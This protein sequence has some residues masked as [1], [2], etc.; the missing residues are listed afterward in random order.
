MKI[1]V[2]QAAARVPVTI[3]AVQGD[4][5]ASNFQSLI[6]A[7]RQAVAAGSA[8][9][10]LDLSGVNYVSSAGL[11]ALH[12]TAVLVQGKQPPD[13]EAGWAAYRAV[14]RDVEQGRQSGVK[15]LNP[16]PG[17]AR[18]LDTSG[19]AQFFE[20]FTDRAAALASF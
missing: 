17:V 6:E 2:E 18:V 15:L 19:M 13:P 16:Q 3:L 5:D 20:V 8:A 9:V 7:A 12:S 11:V 10:L 14:G 1:T 4:I